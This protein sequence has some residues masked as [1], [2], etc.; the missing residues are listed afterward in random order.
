M[1]SELEAS[2]SDSWALGSTFGGSLK[3]LSLD[4][5]QLEVGQA[6]SSNGG[7]TFLSS[8]RGHLHARSPRLPLSAT[9][10][11]QDAVHCASFLTGLSQGVDP[12]ASL[13]MTPKAITKSLADV[14][15]VDEVLRFQKGTLPSSR[16]SWGEG[17][18]SSSTPS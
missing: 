7:E 15:L 8:H 3:R 2:A 10:P 5:A 17:S 13:P 6:S 18:S 11:S 9:G 4:Q 14:A 16:S 12:C 1:G